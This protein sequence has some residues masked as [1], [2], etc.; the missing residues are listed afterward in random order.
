MR[1][2]SANVVHGVL[3]RKEKPKR[4]FLWKCKCGREKVMYE[5]AVSVSC[6]PKRHIMKD[7]ALQLMKL[8]SVN[9]RKPREEDRR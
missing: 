2:R 3:V 5:R 8:V 6:I 7:G 9:G 1:T 4:R